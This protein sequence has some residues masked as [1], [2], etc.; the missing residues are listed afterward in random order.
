MSELEIDAVVFDVLGTLVDEPADIRA[1]IR[2]LDPSLAG[3]HG[4][5]PERVDIGRHRPAGRGRCAAQANPLYSSSA[6]S[7]TSSKPYAPKTTRAPTVSCAISLKSRTSP[8]CSN[9]AGNLAQG[10][11]PPIRRLRVLGA[12]PTPARLSSRS[13]PGPRA[14][15]A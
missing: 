5:P 10:V 7:T 11:T 9:Y 13:H 4:R 15:R 2:E 14:R 6:P 12:P 3:A 8:A 1:G